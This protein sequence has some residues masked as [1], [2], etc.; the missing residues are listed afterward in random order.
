MDLSKRKNLY[1]LSIYLVVLGM[2][3]LFIHEVLKSFA[4]NEMP[5]AYIGFF[6]L[7]IAILI[8]LENRA[9]SF[10]DKKYRLWILSIWI[11]SFFAL[12]YG[13]EKAHTL[14]FLS[15][16]ILPYSFFACF[17]IAARTK[18]WNII[19]KMIYQQFI[20]GLGVFIYIWLT[21]DIKFERSTIELNTM[22]WDAP[23]IYWAWGLLFGWQ[24]MFLSFNKELPTHRKI[25]TILGLVL[26]IVFGMIMLKRQI[27]VEFGMICVFKLIYSIKVQKADI[28][29]WATVFVACTVVT[30][31]V[32][33]FYEIPDNMN[34]LK[35]IALRSTEAGSILDTTLKNTRLHDTPLN[36]YNQATFFELLY[37][38]GLGSVVVKEGVIDNVVE[39]GFFTIFL[40]GGIIYLMI[41]Y[42]GF[43]LILK[44]TFWGMRGEKLLFGLLSAMFIISS[45]MGS[46][47]IYFPSSGYQMFWLGRS[48]SRI[49]EAEPRKRIRKVSKVL[50]KM[51]K[52]KFTKVLT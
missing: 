29:K 40:K 1:P 23:R 7:F 10:L 51:D 14:Q 36:I 47:F 42:F 44:D 41:W 45:P 32:F 34:Y 27:I 6:I 24:Y 31:S 4:V 9:L 19:D 48:A 28:S 17:L 38:Q 49:R 37:G 18:R 21:L 15:R 5:V 20:F 33:M 12:I 2:W 25:A 11:F 16:D 3:I 13:I 46:F 30:F 26:Y 43:L 8:E 50:R 35:R 22:S 39:S 52:D